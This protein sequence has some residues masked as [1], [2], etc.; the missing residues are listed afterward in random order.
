MLCR[1]I[2]PALAV[3]L[4]A[5]C[6]T[7][8]RGPAAPAFDPAAAPILLYSG[9]V[10]SEAH[11][12]SARLSA[13]SA[14]REDGGIVPLRLLDPE[15]VPEAASAQRL[16]AM[17]AL[18]PGR[19]T[20]LE[21]TAAE[22]AIEDPENPASLSLPDG[23]TRVDLVFTAAA[24]R[25]LVVDW[26]L[27]LKA[28]QVDGFRFVPAFRATIPSR[29]PTGLE[30]L[31]SLTDAGLVLT[32]DRRSGRAVGVT[33]VGRRPLGIAIDEARRRA[34]VALA[35]DDALV[36]IDLGQGTIAQRRPV[37]GGDQP[38]DL[39]LRPD[40]RTLLVVNE[41][42]SSI[43]VVDTQSLA[44]EE[45]ID[46]AGDRDSSPSTSPSMRSRSRFNSIGRGG[47]PSSRAGSRTRSSSSCGTT[48]C[49]GG[50]TPAGS[51]PTP[52]PFKCSSTAPRIGSTWRTRGPPTCSSSS[53][54]R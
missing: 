30:G 40:G 45:R 41:G 18:P 5:G 15:V 31:V 39:A 16:V 22:A 28:A 26:E 13:V 7:P 49:E 36:S 35:G 12:L 21:V 34:Y 14:V 29:P 19:Y 42:S 37:R 3:C 10:P 46:L 4:L 52:T 44:E 17:G 11:R 9:P 54:P 23:P 51:P 48:G 24:G 1:C 43:S 53:F 20:G 25:G 27:D 8:A 32:F 50:T 47:R 6:V 33:P 38:V 2:V